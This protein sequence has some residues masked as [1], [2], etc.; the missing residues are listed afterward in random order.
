MRD[1]R[2]IYKSVPLMCESPSA[3]CRAQNPV[4]HGRVKYIKVRHHFLRNH[5]EKE[6]IEMKYIDTGGSWL[7]FLP[8]PLM[9][10]I[11]LLYG[12]NLV[13]AIPMA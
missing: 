9:R 13:F 10:H 12:G 8:N 11:L 3:I 6:D 4:F 1:Y 2:E 7:I 5:V